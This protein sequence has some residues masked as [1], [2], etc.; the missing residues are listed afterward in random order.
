MLRKREHLLIEQAKNADPERGF[1]IKEALR[2]VEARLKQIE[3]A[4]PARRSRSRGLIAS[5][6]SD[7]MDNRELQG[8]R[9]LSEIVYD[10]LCAFPD[11]RPHPD[12]DFQRLSKAIRIANEQLGDAVNLFNLG[13]DVPAKEDLVCGLGYLVIALTHSVQ[14]SQT[15]SK[16]LIA[17]CQAITNIDDIPCHID[18]RCERELYRIAI[19]SRSPRDETIKALLMQWIQP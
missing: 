7:A 12:Y 13:K 17:L 10:A 3:Q 6:L 14:E 19:F 9:V 4:R 2:E 15:L 18:A 1:Q 5:D 8:F 16:A 11:L